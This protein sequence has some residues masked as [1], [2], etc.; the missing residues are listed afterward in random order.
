[1]QRVKTIAGT[2][3]LHFLKSLSLNHL[4]V[5][6]HS[7]CSIGRKETVTAQCD[8]LSLVDVKGY[9]TALCDEHWWLAYVMDVNPADEEAELNFL[10]PH[11]PSPSYCYP[12]HSYTLYVHVSDILTDV[13][14]TTDMGRTYKLS[15]DNIE[16]MRE[17]L[18]KI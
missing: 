9:V 8:G 5:A 4:E 11:G 7:T 6:M 14:P 12:R 1:M 10:H 17:A 18:H 16:K 2:Q 13:H 15:K 3:K